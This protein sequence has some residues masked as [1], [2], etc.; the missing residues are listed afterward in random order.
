M[1]LFGPFGLHVED[2]R[3]DSSAGLLHPLK[4]GC[5]SFRDFATKLGRKDRIF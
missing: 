4:V 1:L 3:I 5:S 2:C